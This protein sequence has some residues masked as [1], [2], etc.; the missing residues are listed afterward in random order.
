MAKILLEVELVCVIK[1]PKWSPF[2]KQ[3]HG[4]DIRPTHVAFNL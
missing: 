3:K 2:A 4:L 1:F